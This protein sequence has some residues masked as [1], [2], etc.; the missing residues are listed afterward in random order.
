MIQNI[1]ISN[2]KSFGNDVR[3]SL[4]PFSVFVGPNAAGKSNLVNAFLFIQDCLNE[5]IGPAVTRQYGWTNLRCRRRRSSSVSFALSGQ[6]SDDEFKLKVGKK[7]LTFSRPCFEYGFS[8][9]PQD[10]DYIVTAESARLS[11]CPLRKGQS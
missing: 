9:S 2:F 1:S 10:D 11:S 3:L 5:G 8:L 6:S 7:E 4:S